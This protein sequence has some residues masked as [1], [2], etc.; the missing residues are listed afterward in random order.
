MMELST[1]FADLGCTFETVFATSIFVSY[2]PEEACKDTSN[3]I[4]GGL[5]EQ[6]RGV[7]F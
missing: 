2:G 1:E 7:G 5:A 4:Q 6:D 3:L